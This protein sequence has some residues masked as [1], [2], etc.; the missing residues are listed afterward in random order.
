M[1][2][3]FKLFSENYEKSW[4]F[5]AISYYVAVEE[6]RKRLSTFS[7]CYPRAKMSCELYRWNDHLDAPELRSVF[8]ACYLP[9]IL[10]KKG[11]RLVKLEITCMGSLEC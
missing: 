2:F 8:S 10:Q 11:L 7:R 3:T 6:A 1:K 4:E 9:P 5:N